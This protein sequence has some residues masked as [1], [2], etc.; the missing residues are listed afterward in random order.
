MQEVKLHLGCGKK[1]FGKSWIHIDGGNFEHLHSHNIRELPFEDE[2]VDLIY[3]SHVLEYFDRDEVLVVLREWKRV[4]KKGGILRLSVPN[5]DVLSRL[6]Q[7]GIPL[8]E[9]VGPLYGRWNMGGKWVYHKTTY[10]YRNL[11]E[12]LENSGF[13]NVRPWDWRNV[14]H[15]IHDDYSQ[16]YKPH[17]DKENGTL[18]SLN[19]ESQK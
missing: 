17:M 10:D 3:A 13:S 8:E 9:V 12:V 2:T 4:L 5:F 6:Y 19:I 1:D 15:G 14:E 16:A 18:I 11:K 7:K